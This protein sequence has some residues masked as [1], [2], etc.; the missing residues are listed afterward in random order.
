[1][2]N[3]LL[4]YLAVLDMLTYVGGDIARWKAGE[5]DAEESMERLHELLF[6]ELDDEGFIQ[7]I[8]DHTLLAFLGLSPKGVEVAKEEGLLPDAV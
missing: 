3:E 6:G 8:A 7:V 4:N 2:D 1:M 5:V